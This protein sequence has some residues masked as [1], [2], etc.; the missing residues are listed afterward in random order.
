MNPK[1]IPVIST[2]IVMAAVAVMIELGIW[3]LGR[4]EQSRI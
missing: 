2:L 1:G 3:Q 4:A